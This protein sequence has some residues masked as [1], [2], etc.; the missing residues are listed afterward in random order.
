MS[1]AIICTG[2]GQPLTIPPGYSRN[3]IQ[4]PGCGVICPLSAETRKAAAAPP[5]RTARKSTA[6]DD[7]LWDAVDSESSSPIPAAPSEPPSLWED[8]T[9]PVEKPAPK[10]LLFPCRRCGKKVRRQGE[11][12]DCDGFVDRGA[13]PG[14]PA[15]EPVLRLSLD[16]D[17]DTEDAEDNG[18]PYTVLGGEERKCPECSKVIPKDAVVCV[19]C[20][21]HLKKRRKIAKTYEP[22]DR[23]WETNYPFALRI[24]IWVMIAAFTLVTGVVGLVIAAELPPFGFVLTWLYFN[25]MVAFLLGTYDR[26]RITRDRRGRSQLI[27]KWRLCF[28]P[29]KET[30]IDVQGYGG[31]SA[32][33]FSEVSLWEWLIFI[34]MLVM[35]ILPAFVWWYFVIHKVIWRVSLTQDHGYVAYIAYHGRDET[36]MKEIARTLSSAAGLTLEGA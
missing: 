1:G 8:P 6:E 10:P 5:A 17:D 29:A 4:C 2:C 18:N 25:G 22:I 19:S 36:Q 28:V 24:V 27:K 9:P 13:P 35:G 11:C 20:G 16:D 26:I 33:A 32:G 23:T 3:K 31:V 30:V 7:I 21:Y 15:A 34:Q 12:P 14:A